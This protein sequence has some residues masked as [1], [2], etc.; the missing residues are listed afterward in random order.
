MLTV[1]SND[2]SNSSD[3]LTDSENAVECLG[4]KP[5]PHVPV[6]RGLAL[7]GPAP[8]VPVPQGL[9]LQGPAPHRYLVLH[10][11]PAL[12]PHRKTAPEEKKPA[13]KLPEPEDPQ[14]SA[15]IVAADVAAVVAAH[16]TLAPHGKLVLKEK[17]PAHAAVA[18]NATIFAVAA[19]IEELVAVATARAQTKS[20][21]PRAQT[22]E[23]KRQSPDK[24]L[25]GT[26]TTSS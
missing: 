25:D 22:P 17:K 1:N 2:G 6:P 11:N 15:I 23:P 4:T 10:R 16:R 9:A 20:L 8:H 14:F 13:A 19:D 21:T 18:R 3:S 7:Q 24:E 5:V 12:Q 26:Q